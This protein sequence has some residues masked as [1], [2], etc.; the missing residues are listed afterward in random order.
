MTFENDIERV[1]AEH[2]ARPGAS[3]EEIAGLEARLG[4][5][6]PEDMVAFYRRCDGASLFGHPDSPFRILP[7]REV[8]TMREFMYGSSDERYGPA[9][10]VCFCDTLDRSGL[11]IELAAGPQYGEVWDCYP[12]VWPEDGFVVASS[13]TQF[14]SRVLASGG[15]HWW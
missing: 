5:R 9:S 14:L 15:E 10:L 12:L 6:L 4:R 8:E 13:F 7:I 3:A 2:H 1:F 11:A